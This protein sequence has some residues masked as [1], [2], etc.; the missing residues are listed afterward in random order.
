VRVF[1]RWTA[2]WLLAL[3]P[4]CSREEA[5][6]PAPKSPEIPVV[7]PVGIVAELEVPEPRRLWASLRKLGGSRAAFLPSSFE[8]ALFSLLEL[9][10]RAAGYLRPDTPLVGVVL[11]RPGTPATA[12]LAVRATSGAEL[13]R[14]LTSGSEA[15]LRVERD[16]SPVALLVGR[17]DSSVLG[18]V[19][20]WLLVGR[21]ASALR[22]AGA[23]L[24]RGV[25]ARRP[26]TDP[27]TLRIEGSALAGPISAGLREHWAALRG[28]LAEKDRAARKLHGRAP[29]F[30]DPAA[31]LGLADGVVA[32]TLELA[33]STEHAT[34][35][36]EPESEHVELRVSLVPRKDGALARFAEGLAVGPLDPLLE[37]PNGVLFAVLSRSS[38]AELARAAETPADAVR[39]V[40]GPRLAE[41][42]AAP[43]AEAL[44][45]Y[46]RGRGAVTAFGLLA[47]GSAFL[48]Q[49]V[50]EPKELERGL[51]GLVR[52]LSIPAL[53]EP[54]EPIIG[55][56][57]APPS[58]ARIAGLDG[59]VQR[60][61]L[62]RRSSGEKLEVLSYVRRANASTVMAR[63]ATDVVFALERPAEG[64]LAS[65]SG[66]PTLARDR[67]PSAFALYANLP[68]AGAPPPPAPALG[69]LGKD[70]QTA[71]L[72]LAL[73]A[74]ACAALLERFGSP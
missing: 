17:P 24:A 18:V 41:K 4:G 33:A 37:L 72:E 73:S 12:V 19:D 47:D 51:S 50:R 9:P 20:D 69:L 22:A 1:F 64:S 30:A 27:L 44:A 49:T 14:E 10:P 25:G 29:D 21:D 40:L 67:V 43:L 32:S 23:Y 5:P 56:L 3:A 46:H 53:A 6:A 8:L 66:L 62:T 58:A 48:R 60:A 35:T 31:V 57:T 61:E 55:K 45:N 59:R 36:L 63:R 38:D 54:L 7:A 39:A 71:V 65:A 42:D 68:S 34:L 26:R 28:E 2:A 52:L 16:A 13:V 74:P 11:L 70:G 15:P